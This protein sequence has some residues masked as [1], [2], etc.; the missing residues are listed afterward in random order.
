MTLEE[1]FKKHLILD[2]ELN[3]L[4]AEKYGKKYLIF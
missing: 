1:L 2:Y 3:I 4:Q